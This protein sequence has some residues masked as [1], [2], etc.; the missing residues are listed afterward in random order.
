MHNPD[1]KICKL[2]TLSFWVSAF[3]LAV[4]I[5]ALIIF[6]VVPGQQYYSFGSFIAGHTIGFALM[7]VVRHL[8]Y[9]GVNQNILF[10]TWVLSIV[11]ATS[12]FYPL[13]F[14]VF[15]YSER[16][17]GHLLFPAEMTYFILGF[18]L[19]VNGI[20]IMV[21]LIVSARSKGNETDPLGIADELQR[22]R[23][24]R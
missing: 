24:H 18:A 14:I 10:F 15:Q 7:L 2:V 21:A 12:S 3:Y 1:C 16:H 23:T 22:L 9:S 6:F 20:L 4:P 13:R 8:S 17:R 19:L 11:A 5:V